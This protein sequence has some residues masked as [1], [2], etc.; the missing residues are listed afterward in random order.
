MDG[1]WTMA[2]RTGRQAGWAV[3]W[4]NRRKRRDEWE[5][6]ETETRM[7]EKFVGRSVE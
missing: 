4:L 7:F 6:A 1:G 5:I 2:D 3:G